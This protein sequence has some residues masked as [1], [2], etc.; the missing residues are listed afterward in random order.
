VALLAAVPAARPAQ[1]AGAADSGGGAACFFRRDW[2]GGWKA[3]PDARTIYIVVAGRTYRLELQSPYPL[4][5]SSWALLTNR[6]ASNTICAPLDFRLV[7][8]DRLGV[9]QPVI[10]TGMAL[11]SPAEAASLPPD[12]R[13]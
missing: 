7:V 3:T 5:K 13:P 10:V 1:P 6:D 11:L 9:H 12:L 4:L 8:S 2:Q